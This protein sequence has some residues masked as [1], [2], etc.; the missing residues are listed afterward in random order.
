MDLALDG[1]CCQPLRRSRQEE[2]D[3]MVVSDLTVGPDREIRGDEPLSP[4]QSA[5]TSCH[6]PDHG[7]VSE[8]RDRAR[9]GHALPDRSERDPSGVTISYGARLDER[10]FPGRL[11]LRL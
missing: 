5:F 4:S 11:N 6:F 8:A 1:T 2:T 9:P 10:A 7:S 3:E